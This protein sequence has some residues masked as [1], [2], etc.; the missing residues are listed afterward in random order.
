[1]PSCVPACIKN[2]ARFDLVSMM[3]CRIAAVLVLQTNLG[4]RIGAPTNWIRHHQ[5]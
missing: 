2:L 1:M 5:I 4:V 3:A